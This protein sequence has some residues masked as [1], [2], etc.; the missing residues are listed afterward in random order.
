MIAQHLTNNNFVSEYMNYY[1]MRQALSNLQMED[2][3]IN[4][5]DPKRNGEMLANMKAFKNILNEK[6]DKISPYDLI[7][8]SYVVNGEQYS[9]GFRKTQV[10]VPR[11]K[12]FTPCSPSRIPEAIYS[13]FNAYN[14]IWCNLNPYEREARLHIELVRI[15]PFE[16]GNK[17][18]ARILTSYNLIMN[19]KAP[20]IITAEEIDEYFNY[21]DEYNV[22]GMT[23]FF[24]KK[25]IDEFDIMLELYQNMCGDDFKIDNEQ[26]TNEVDD[27]G[28]K[29]YQKKK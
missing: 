14:N 25:S 23:E 15:Q 13:V 20:I 17:R 8:I 19:N 28:V 18:S 26:S 22:K 12:N 5:L 24:T 16:D 7:D 10:D 1:A 11:A 2:N 6:P 21:I 3:S 4:V 9:K 27:N 29:I